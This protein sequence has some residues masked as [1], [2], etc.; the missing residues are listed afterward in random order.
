[1]LPIVPTGEVVTVAPGAS[2]PEHPHVFAFSLLCARKLDAACLVRAVSN[3]DDC[4]ACNGPASPSQSDGKNTR[5]LKKGL[6]RI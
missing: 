3:F 4:A 1:M 6:F 5:S 2:A